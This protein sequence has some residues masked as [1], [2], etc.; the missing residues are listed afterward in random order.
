MN[1]NKS[2]HRTINEPFIVVGSFKNKHKEQ[3]MKRVK[4]INK[5]LNQE[6]SKDKSNGKYFFIIRDSKRILDPEYQ[7]F[8]VNNN[9][10]FKKNPGEKKEYKRKPWEM[11]PF[12][13]LLS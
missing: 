11:N 12:K 13:C 5:N 6:I 9:V 1:L 7:L 3:R 10:R 4:R 2:I 8:E